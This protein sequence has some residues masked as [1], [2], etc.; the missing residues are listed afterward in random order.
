MKFR[1]LFYIPFVSRQIVYLLG[2]NGV[3]I[4]LGTKI[5]LD[6]LPPPSS[7]SN[8]GNKRYTT[9]YQPIRKVVASE[10]QKKSR[11]SLINKRLRL[12]YFI[13]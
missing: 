8:L 4:M 7:K 3:H 10:S 9:D 13:N 5:C 1:T 11:K 6:R 2:I 12:F